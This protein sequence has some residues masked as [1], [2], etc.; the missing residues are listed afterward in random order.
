[1]VSRVHKKRLMNGDRFFVSGTW[2][3][4]GKYPS[5]RRVGSSEVV[6]YVLTCSNAA[7]SGQREHDARN[8]EAN[9][10]TLDEGDDDD[11]LHGDHSTKALGKRWNDFVVA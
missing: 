4:S 1:M 9:L 5:R 8:Q 7:D 2:R 3:W 6:V 11:V 10:G